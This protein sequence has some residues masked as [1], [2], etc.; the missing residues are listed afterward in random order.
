MQ[1]DRTP[2]V[3]IRLAPGEVWCLR[4][5]NAG[6]TS[7]A[8]SLDRYEAVCPVCGSH[9]WVDATTVLQPTEYYIT[10]G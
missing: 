8:R 2:A 6:N 3:V 10:A 7:Q 4:C 9:D 1:T 5:G